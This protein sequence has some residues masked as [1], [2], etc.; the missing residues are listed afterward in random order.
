MNMIP[1]VEIW[2]KVTAWR[3]AQIIPAGS[4]ADSILEEFVESEGDEDNNQD[5]GDGEK[6]T[7]EIRPTV[8]VLDEKLAEM[9][10]GMEER[11]EGTQVA[12]GKH[13][14]TSDKKGT[15]EGDQE[16]GEDGELEERNEN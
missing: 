6:D 8:E 14:V 2:I 12:E 13:D 1:Y 16:A 11:Q 7:G 10:R 15:Q 9:I 3:L 5:V 4:V